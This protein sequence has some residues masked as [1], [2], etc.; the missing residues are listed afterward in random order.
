MT[1]ETPIR[2]RAAYDADATPEY[3]AEDVSDCEELLRR[4]ANYAE[5]NKDPTVAAELRRGAA[6]LHAEVADD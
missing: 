6:V 2:P 3:V 5:A 4:A 1:E